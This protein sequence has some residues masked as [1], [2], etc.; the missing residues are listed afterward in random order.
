MGLGWEYYGKQAGYTQKQWDALPQQKKD[1]IKRF[2]DGLGGGPTVGGALNTVA[3][4]GGQGF[5]GA[6][7]AAG[8][9]AAPPPQQG[10]GEVFTQDGGGDGADNYGGGGSP[11][12]APRPL[13]T[14]PEWLAYLN[15]LG[16]EE[17]QFRADIDKQRA[18]AKSAADFQMAGIGPE[19]DKQRRGIGG[20][21]G[22]RGLS[23]SGETQRRYAENRAEEG[24]ARTGVTMGLGQTLAGLESQLANKMM[25]LGARKASQELSLRASGYV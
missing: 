16:L 10:G 1:E 23:S 5:G 11:Y 4:G 9:F 24:R 20:V 15:A 6:G 17:S 7:Q 18:F 8:G 19:Y 2:I 3:F 13:A 12:Q 14:S 22:S 21:M 25:D